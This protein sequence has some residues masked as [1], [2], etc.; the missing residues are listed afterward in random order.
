[1]TNRL[2]V[3][4]LALVTACAPVGGERYSRKQAQKSLK[5]LEAPGIVVGEFD[6]TK[7]VDGDTIKV[8]GLD[9][10]LRLIGDDTEETF[11]NEADR[12]E[13]E[14]GFE[15]YIKAKKG[16]STRPVKGATPMGEQAKVFAKNWFA[17]VDKV[18]IERDHPAEIRDRYNRYLAYVFANKKGTWVN[19]NIEVVRAGMSP[20]FPKYGNS[21]RFHAEFVAAQDEA[22]QAKRGIWQ[23]GAPAYPDYA[24]REAWWVAR[25]NFVDAFR[26]E[27][28]GKSNYID[29]THWD[30]LQQLEANLGKEVKLLGTVGDVRIGEKGPTRVT[31]SRRLFADF[32]LIFFDRDVLGTSG[33]SEWKSEY[34]IVTGVPTFYENKHNKKKQLQIQIDRASQITLC[35]VPGL[36]IPTASASK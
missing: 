23:P 32:P 6:L 14:A 17:G 31:L 4:L 18:R 5:K 24:E 22:K 8:E 7:I 33:I 36:S 12:R 3:G 20:Y 21:R 9:S 26:K 10:S 29:I 16:N 28:E 25:G 35:P 27:G 34:V 2:L 19:Y 1:M 15:A 11:K 13:A 30:A